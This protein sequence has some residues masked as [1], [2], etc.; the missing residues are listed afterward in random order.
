LGD[1]QVGLVRLDY[2]R[3]VLL[4]LLFVAGFAALGVLRGTPVPLEVSD[5]VPQGDFLRGVGLLPPVGEAQIGTAVRAEVD[6]LARG[7][8]EQADIG[9]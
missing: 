9:Q 2:S 5:V 8:E 3:V 1:V 4:F 6:D 7:V